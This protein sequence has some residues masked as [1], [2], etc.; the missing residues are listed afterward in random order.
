M[1]HEDLRAAQHDAD[2]QTHRA[3]QSSQIVTDKGDA[4]EPVSTIDHVQA[5][6]DHAAASDAHK[7]VVAHHEEKANSILND[8]AGRGVMHPDVLEDMTDKLKRHL[9]Q[10]NDSLLDIA[11]HTKAMNYHA[12]K[13]T[14]SNDDDEA[15]AALNVVLE[16]HDMNEWSG[17]LSFKATPA[18]STGH[19]VHKQKY[20]DR[21]IVDGK[22]V[23]VKDAHTGDKGAHEK[24]KH[25]ATALSRI[26]GLTHKKEPSRAD[27]S[28]AELKGKASVIR[29][30]M[31]EGI[32]YTVSKLGFNTF[33]AEVKEDDSIIF[34][35]KAP[36]EQGAISHMERIIDAAISDVNE[37]VSN[38]LNA[39]EISKKVAINK[40][41][42][43]SQK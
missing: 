20:V 9:E 29:H 28:R 4:G 38:P 7:K 41:P 27:L 6:G 5:F 13:L 43:W 18:P 1:S 31:K 11:G 15:I 32:E 42:L 10:R 23:H 24:S 16:Q 35:C 8:I 34:E 37:S 26:M 40:S 33:I 12:K 19:T 36:T 39:L 22:E 30:V 2:D 17:A 3:N 21:D 25:D 14:E